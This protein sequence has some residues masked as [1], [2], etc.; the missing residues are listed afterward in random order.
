[1]HSAVKL[2]ALLVY[3]L[4]ARKKQKM[5]MHQCRMFTFQ[6]ILLNLENPF[7]HT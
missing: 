3:F 2:T 6:M 4:P 7:Q 5:C 1:M